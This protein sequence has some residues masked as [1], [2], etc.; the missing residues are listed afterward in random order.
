MT[1]EQY[2]LEYIIDKIYDEIDFVDVKPYSHNIISIWF[3]ILEEQ[4]GKG[5]VVEIIN[6]TDLYDAGW[7][8]IVDEYW[9][10]RDRKRQEKKAKKK[11]LKIVN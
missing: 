1:T 7:G 8:W 6:N 2:E 3:R 9:E 4:Y 5:E 10:E 11:K